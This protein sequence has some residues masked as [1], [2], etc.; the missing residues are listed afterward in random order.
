LQ[1]FVKFCC[2]AGDVV[3]F[4]RKVCKAGKDA[5]RRNVVRPLV[6]NAVSGTVV[7]RYDLSV[8]ND[9]K[10]FTCPHDDGQVS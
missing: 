7:H 6:F 5:D 3:D 8:A 1:S 10:F 4:D 2:H 9:S